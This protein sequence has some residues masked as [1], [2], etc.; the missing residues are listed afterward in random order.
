MS[1]RRRRRSKQALRSPQRLGEGGRVGSGG[2]GWALAALPRSAP[3][4]CCLDDVLYE[5][6][7]YFGAVNT[8]H[9]DRSAVILKKD[10]PSLIFASYI[11]KQGSSSEIPNRLP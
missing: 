4:I 11:Q 10:V 6:Y 8:N 2:R 9:H 1:C 7:F 3:L 5:V